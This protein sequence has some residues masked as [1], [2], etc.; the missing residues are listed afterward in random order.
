VKEFPLA[1]DNSKLD[2]RALPEKLVSDA[3]LQKIERRGYAIDGKLV[4]R[5]GNAL[6]EGNYYKTTL[7]LDSF[8]TDQNGHKFLTRD[9]RP[10]TLSD[11][12]F[13]LIPPPIGMGSINFAQNDSLASKI[14]ETP[15]KEWAPTADYI[16]GLRQQ[17]KSFTAKEDR[18][19]FALAEALAPFVPDSLHE[20]KKTNKTDGVVL[21]EI[22]G[23]LS[24]GH[25]YLLTRWGDDTLEALSLLKYMSSYGS[26]L[27]D[28][29]L[30]IEDLRARAQKV[31][32]FEQ[33]VSALTRVPPH[34]TFSSFEDFEKKS[35]EYLH[36]LQQISDYA[37]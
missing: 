23:G 3:D 30:K 21:D 14:F 4:D 36:R 20:K 13:G 11:P 17:R 33:A 10:L 35:A 25:K 7:H 29:N 37:P 19:K 26:G 6:A 9:G 32:D 12:S 16:E 34:F 5:M 27:V 8:G 24:S 28:A 2:W 31:Y 18:Q 1:E 15:T 22:N